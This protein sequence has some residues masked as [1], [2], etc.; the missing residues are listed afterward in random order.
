MRTSILSPLVWK[1][2]SVTRVLLTL[3]MQV[4]TF[5]VDSHST[6]DSFDCWQVTIVMK[7]SS[8]EKKA[9]QIGSTR[10]R[11][12]R[13]E[14]EQQDREQTFHIVSYSHVTRQQRTTSEVYNFI[15]PA[16][17]FFQ[18]TSQ[19]DQLSLKKDSFGVCAGNT[20][21]SHMHHNM[22][23]ALSNID[24]CYWHSWHWKGTNLN[25]RRKTK[26]KNTLNWIK[27]INE[28]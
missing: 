2:Y 7:K 22:Q 9:S 6:C 1:N 19:N 25:K 13:R 11:P 5:C 27:F 23:D 3:H 16:W 24:S 10:Y 26:Q 14:P 17:L 15:T 18:E 20:S 4:D 12:R 8:A 28:I 21:K